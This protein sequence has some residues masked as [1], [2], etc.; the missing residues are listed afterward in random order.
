MQNISVNKSI[1]C[2]YCDGI[3]AAIRACYLIRDNS[4]MGPWSYKHRFI[5]ATRVKWQHFL[6]QFKSNYKTVRTKYTY[7][8]IEFFIFL[9]NSDCYDCYIC[10]S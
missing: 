6:I 4:M 3:S 5:R 9:S 7:D 10:D 8:R 2:D 1:K